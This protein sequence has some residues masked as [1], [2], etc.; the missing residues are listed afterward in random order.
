MTKISDNYELLIKE[1]HEALLRND[2]VENIKVLHNVK[3]KGK[4]GAPHQI[5]V[6]W[7]FKLAGITYKTCI[8]CKYLTNAVKKTHIAAFSTILDDIGNATGIFATSSHFQSGAKLL[9]KEKGIRLVLVNYLFKTINIKGKFLI[10]DLIYIKDVEFDKEN[11]REVFKNKGLTNY[12]YPMIVSGED[13]LYDATGKEKG[14]IKDILRPLTGKL[15]EGLVKPENTYYQ[16]EI[17]N[18]KLSSI[19]YFVSHSEINHEQT[20]TVNDVSKAILK[21]VLDNTSCYL[22]DNGSITEIET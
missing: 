1:L 19:T 6:Y 17:G 9:A 20:I 13:C 3:I 21:D 12:S 10:P 4:S 5:D 18:V 14:H 22:N 7:E 11:A 16:T 2:G 15:G 8:E